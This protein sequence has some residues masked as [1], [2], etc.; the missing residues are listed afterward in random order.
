MKITHLKKWFV[1]G[2]MLIAISA[3]TPHHSK[4]TKQGS[5]SSSGGTNEPAPGGNEEIEAMPDTRTASF[6]SAN[7]ALDAMVSCLGTSEPSRAS[8]EIWD[9][10]KGS[11]S[12]TGRAN[13]IT[14]PMMSS[15]IKISAEVCNDLVKQEN[16]VEAGKRRIFPQ[17]DFAGGA[18]ASGAVQDSIRRLARSCWGRNENASELAMLE[19]SLQEAFA[20]ADGSDDVNREKA[21][22]LC[23][24]MV[25]SFSTLE[26]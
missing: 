21:L 7:R 5:Q 13:S 6:V 9:K 23:T 11:L 1:L 22:Y 3:C 18:L 8:K 19:S 14:P 20:E 4:P 15:L 16:S 26:M 2:G 10:N 17:F 24:T 12:T 25:S